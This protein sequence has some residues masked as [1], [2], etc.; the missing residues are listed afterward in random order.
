MV[1]ALSSLLMDKASPSG[2]RK[3]LVVLSPGQRNPVQLEPSATEK[4]TEVTRASLQTE[5]NDC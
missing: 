2:C 3:P 4:F 5:E 1:V